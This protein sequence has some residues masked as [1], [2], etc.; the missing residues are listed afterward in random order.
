MKTQ[1]QYKIEFYVKEYIIDA[2][3][4]ASDIASKDFGIEVKPED[5]AKAI[6]EVKIGQYGEEI[7]Y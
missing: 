2:L 4:K 6:V 1:R 5:I 7:I 3:E